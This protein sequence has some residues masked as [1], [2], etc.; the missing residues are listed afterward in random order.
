MTAQTLN[1]N[2]QNPQI[3]DS[4]NS[5]NSKRKWVVF[6]ILLL[7]LLLAAFILWFINRPKEFCDWTGKMDIVTAKT[8]YHDYSNCKLDFSK[9]PPKSKIELTIKNG[10]GKATV[11]TDLFAGLAKILPSGYQ[12]DPICHLYDQSANSDRTIECK[13]I[14]P[15]IYTLGMEGGW[16]TAGAK[17]TVEYSIKLK[18]PELC[19]SYFNFC[20]KD[21]TNQWKIT[22]DSFNDFDLVNDSRGLGLFFVYSRGLDFKSNVPGFTIIKFSNR[23]NL[24]DE[25]AYKDNVDGLTRVMTGTSIDNVTLLIMLASEKDITAYDVQDI[26]NNLD[27]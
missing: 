27:Y 9:V 2:S 10:K 4:S 8:E 11:S 21:T 26:A 1:I 15:D 16:G 5:E 12:T 14:K 13:I 19:S 25:P 20:F 7:L 18:E 17:N 22:T 3:V 24:H 23:H 6:I